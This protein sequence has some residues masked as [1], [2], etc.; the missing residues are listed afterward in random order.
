[1][2]LVDSTT[3]DRLI[4]F[5]MKIEDRVERF[6]NVIYIIL[7]EALIVRQAWFL[8]IYDGSPQSVSSI[9]ILIES[10]EWMLNLFTFLNWINIDLYYRQFLRCAQEIIDDPYITCTIALL[11]YTYKVSPIIL[12]TV[13]MQWDLQRQTETCRQTYTSLYTRYKVSRKSNLKLEWSGEQ[14][15]RSFSS[16]RHCLLHEHDNQAGSYEAK[17]HWHFFQL[18]L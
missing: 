3:L 13:Q 7:F 4:A 1:M 5:T 16:A 6:S 15:W 12:K 18:R 9:C 8:N 2:G 11:T 14:T 10:C 17:H